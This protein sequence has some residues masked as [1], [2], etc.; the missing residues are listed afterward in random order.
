MNIKLGVSEGL[1]K[2]SLEWFQQICSENMPISM[3][4]LH[5]KA[6]DTGLHLKID[7]FKALNG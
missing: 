5:Q 7:N 2:I 4:I 6:A 1:E 3:S